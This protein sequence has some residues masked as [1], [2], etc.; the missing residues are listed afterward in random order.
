MKDKQKLTPY[1]KGI[2]ITLI[3]VM[4]LSPDSILIRLANVDVITNIFYRGIFLS[5]WMF[6]IVCITHKKNSLQKLIQIDK[7]D[8]LLVLSHTI[9]SF[10]FVIAISYTTIAKALLII[11]ISPIL[12]AVLSYIFLSE[13]ISIYTFITLLAT[14][15]GFGIIFY[16]NENWTVSWIG[17][18][19]ALISAFV[20]STT[21]IV[22]RY[23]K[24]SMM[25]PL[26]YSGLLVAIICIFF[27][28][29]IPTKSLLILLLQGLLI[30]SAFALLTLGPKYIPATEVNLIM[31]VETILSILI[32]A[33][34]LQEI[35]NLRVLLGGIIILLILFI[36]YSYQIKT[37]K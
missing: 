17:N 15:L 13:K 18:L 19:A 3:G 33:V 35:P 23:K 32:A 2:I 36:Y 27:I 25:I 26:L 16:E 34:F 30:A 5:L 12:S 24:Q 14:F 21:F 7:F 4:I 28:I 11:S 10:S 1:V 37:V 20:L 29:P 9:G 22:A 8:I 31:L 6:I